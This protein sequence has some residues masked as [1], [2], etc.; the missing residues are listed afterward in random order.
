MKTRKT[1]AGSIELAIVIAAVCLAWAGSAIAQK[2]DRYSREEADIR[3]EAE[4]FVQAFNQSDAERPASRWTK[5]AEYTLPFRVVPNGRA[6]RE[7]A[8]KM[9]LYDNQGIQVQLA[10]PEIRFPHVAFRV[11]LTVIF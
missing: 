7:Q 3:I 6:K 2:A 11:K 5:G 4:S 1:S 8:F 9:F 10:L